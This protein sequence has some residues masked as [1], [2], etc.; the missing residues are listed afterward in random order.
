[1]HV[2]RTYTATVSMTK[3]INHQMDRAARVIRSLY[4]VVYNIM[5]TY[6]LYVRCNL[7]THVADILFYARQG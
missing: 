3:L 7:R 1:M 4:Y 2:L 6:F 5:Y